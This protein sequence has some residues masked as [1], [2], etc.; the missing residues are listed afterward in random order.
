MPSNHLLH[1]P[2]N[3]LGYTRSERQNITMKRTLMYTLAIA[4]VAALAMAQVK[5]RTQGNTQ[6]PARETHVTIAGKTIS[7]S[8]S[9]PSVRGRKLFGAGGLISGDPTYPVWRAGA[10]DATTIHTD[11][12]L[13]LHGLA[14]PAGDYSLFVALDANPWQLIVNKQ[15]GQWGLSYNKSMDL[16][17]VAM[18]IAKP[19]A[20]IETYKMTLSSEGG[21]RGK[22]TLEW[23]NVIASVPFTV[24]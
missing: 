6:S 18:T 24:K 4:A 9:A 19:A 22:L 20:P 14:V 3:R 5:P 21:N 8:Y 11:A 16:G 23:E 2:S 1:E 17:R 13:D 12:A 10:D 15:T 7:I